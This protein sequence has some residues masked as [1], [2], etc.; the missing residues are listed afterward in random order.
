MNDYLA[1]VSEIPVATFKAEVTSIKMK[2]QL[3]DLICTNQYIR[4]WLC[5]IY[6]NM[7]DDMSWQKELSEHSQIIALATQVK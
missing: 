6:T 3:G 4:M 7:L 1:A 5:Q 2:F